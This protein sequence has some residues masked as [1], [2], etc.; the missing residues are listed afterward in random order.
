MNIA[1]GHSN[2]DFDCLGS[3]ILIKKLFPD[4]RL[5]RSNHISPAARNLFDFYEGY[6][7]FLTPKDLDGERID[8]IIIVDTCMAERVA[9]YLTHIR[10]SDPEILIYDH[11]DTGGCNILGARIAGAPLGANTS[12]LGRLAMAKSLVLSP[13]E[14]TIALTGIYADT[15]RLIYEN[16]RRDDY[17]VAAWL[18]DMGASLKLVQSFLEVV[19]EDEQIEVMNRLLQKN[20]QRII[21]GHVVLL[22]YLEL[23]EN[24]SGL[25]A[26]VE[27]VMDV[28]NPD[29]YFA[30][31]YIAKN[32]TVLL[33]ARSRRP[34]I[35]LHQILHV[36][37]GGG[38]Q[39]AASAQIR[40]REGPFFYE[41]FL[42]Y[43]ETTLTPAVRAGD[44]MT[45]EVISVHESRS[46]MEASQMMEESNHSGMPVLNDE[47]T[48]TGYIG[49]KDIMKGR[50]AAAM[51]S[52]VRAYMVKPAISAVENIT[53]REVERLFFK[54]HI[55]HLP[56][57]NEGKLT[58]IVSRWDFLQ[59]QK[60]RNY[61]E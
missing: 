51:K 34:A 56:I 43:L 9:E 27:K 4:Y 41:E 50:K 19:K 33:I 49:L 46:L 58:G 38:H 23:E 20:T 45:R 29:A 5:I 16:V 15:G 48:V 13:E 8:R 25:A 47:G 57:V 35:D 28:E 21:Q 54:H 32:K 2:T 6:F 40:D 44:I 36:Y 3:L 12:Y 59:Y 1:F 7:D 37:G 30:V 10:D 52:P 14:A 53:M 17:E 39:G 18:L 22:S 11:H 24:V 31:F 26:V 42:A 55:G 60:R 61:H